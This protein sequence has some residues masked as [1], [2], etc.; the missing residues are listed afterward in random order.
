MIAEKQVRERVDNWVGERR[1]RVDDVGVQ[2]VKLDAA[3]EGRVDDVL[4]CHD[5][6]RTHRGRYCATL[7]HLHL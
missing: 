6:R 3:T 2:D 4:S 5:A 1:Q 7:R